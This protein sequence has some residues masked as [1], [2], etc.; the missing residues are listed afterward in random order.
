MFAIEK[1]LESTDADTSD[2]TIRIG[3]AHS[4][5]RLAQRQAT[6]GLQNAT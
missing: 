6:V 1:S 2:Y 3:K 4:R 5:S